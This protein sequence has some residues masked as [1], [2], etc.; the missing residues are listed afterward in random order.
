MPAYRA[1]VVALVVFTVPA[2][3]VAAK[4]SNTVEVTPYVALGSEATSPVGTAVTFPLTSRLSLETDVAYRRGEGR[5][6]ALSSNVSVL[7]LLPRVCQATSYVAAG[8]GLAIRGAGVLFRR[9]SDRDAVAPGP[10]SECWR[11]PE[12]ADE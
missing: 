12:D 5:I 10:H 4:E 11:R 8:V 9:S 1:A 7:W 2:I 3:P 6:N